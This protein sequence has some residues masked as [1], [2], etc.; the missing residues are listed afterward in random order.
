MIRKLRNALLAFAS[1]SGVLAVAL[2]SAAPTLPTVPGATP[3][4]SMAAMQADRT[5]PATSQIR[6]G[7]PSRRRHARRQQS[8]SMPYFSFGPALLNARSAP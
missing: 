7:T 1:A 6:A 5:E 8:V 2:M 4:V 3:V